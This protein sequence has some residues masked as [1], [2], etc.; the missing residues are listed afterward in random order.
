MSEPGGIELNPEQ[1]KA[2]TLRADLAQTIT[3]CCLEHA[4]QIADK[5][6]AEY[7]VTPKRPRRYP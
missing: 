4:A 2:D 6:L 3:L 1:F 7:K 5:I